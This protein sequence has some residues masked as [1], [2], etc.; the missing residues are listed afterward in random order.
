MEKKKKKK[1]KKN[2]KKKQRKGQKKCHKQG[3][4][5]IALYS[6]EP[7]A[8]ARNDIGAPAMRQW[9]VKLNPLIPHLCV[10]YI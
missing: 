1:K 9:G 8:P 3:N 5:E 7:G 2:L 4:L 6:S 10:S